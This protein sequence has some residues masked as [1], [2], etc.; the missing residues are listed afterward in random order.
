MQD[1]SRLMGSAPFVVS[2]KLKGKIKVPTKNPF[3]TNDMYIY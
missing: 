2:G 3:F 1:A